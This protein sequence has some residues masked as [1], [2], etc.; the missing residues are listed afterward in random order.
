MDAKGC[1]EQW[2]RA[3]ANVARVVDPI[4]TSSSADSSS[5]DAGLSSSSFA[6]SWASSDVSQNE[7]S[8]LVASTAPP[9]TAVD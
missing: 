1:R 5:W 3:W 9:K 2:Q 4:S 8:T 6:A 7:N